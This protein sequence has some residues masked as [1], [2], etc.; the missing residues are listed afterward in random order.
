[1][2]GETDLAT[3]L[4]EGD[5]TASL[6]E[7]A[8][9]DPGAIPDQLVEVNPKAIYADAERVD[10]YVLQMQRLIPGID[11]NTAITELSAMLDR[12]YRQR[13]AE[14]D[15]SIINPRR[16]P[17]P[18]YVVW[19]STGE[20]V[21]QFRNHTL[22]EL[23]HALATYIQEHPGQAFT[24]SFVQPTSTPVNYM[25]PAATT[26]AEFFKLVEWLRALIDSVAV[27]A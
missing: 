13:T 26:D 7:L 19:V 23:M 8:S 27:K 15:E 16:L 5:G 12:L 9:T 11:R 14:L 10:Q 24:V 22:D 2:S 17:H 6:G 20:G 25:Y 18:P 1:M 3:V 4:G 21:I